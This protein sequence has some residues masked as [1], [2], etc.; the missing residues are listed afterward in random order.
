MKVL[1][2]TQIAIW[3]LT[4]TRRLNKQAKTLIADYTNDV[5]V[6]AVSVWEIAMKFALGKRAGAPPVLGRSRARCVSRG[7]IPDAE[8]Y[9]A[10]CRQPR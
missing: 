10:T 1:L 3:A 6:S 9:A 7:G 4:D 2:D 5:F 8:C